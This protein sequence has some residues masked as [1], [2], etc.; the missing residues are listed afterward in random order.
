[1]NISNFLRS[2]VVS[3][4]SLILPMVSGGEVKSSACHDNLSPQT[5]EIHVLFVCRDGE[6]MSP[7]WEKKLKTILDLDD[8][9][10]V[11]VSHISLSK[12]TTAQI[13]R[14]QDIVILLVDPN[15]Y[16]HDYLYYYS[17][18]SAQSKTQILD[19]SSSKHIPK[20]II[21]YND[22]THDIYQALYR[23]LLTALF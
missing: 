9:D 18:H 14:G 10:N 11:V 7:F 12:S 22:E 2:I 4:C 16:Q 20:E 13:L 8:V 19:L 1:M 5:K 6:V 23:Y 3:F 15:Q 21:Q 17:D